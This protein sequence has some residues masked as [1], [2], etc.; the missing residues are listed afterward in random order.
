MIQTVDTEIIMTWERVIQL[1]VRPQLDYIFLLSLYKESNHG[2]ISC[3]HTNFWRG[4]S[5]SHR[6]RENYQR[7]GGGGTIPKRV[8]G[9]EGTS[10]WGQQYQFTTVYNIVHLFDGMY[11]TSM[12]PQR[13]GLP[14][15]ILLSIPERKGR[16]HFTFSI[17]NGQHP[18]HVDDGIWCH[19]MSYDIRI[20]TNTLLWTNTLLC[21]DLWLAGFLKMQKKKGLSLMTVIMRYMAIKNVNSFTIRFKLWTLC[22]S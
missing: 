19:K 12:H 16:K 9:K 4:L 10:T 14:S 22:V 20:R 13:D 17:R 8:M 11:F 5:T 18:K 6:E 3:A 2:S 1:L 7:F 15:H 21:G